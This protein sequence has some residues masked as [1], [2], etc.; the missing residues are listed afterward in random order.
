MKGKVG[1]S[2]LDA[3]WKD[4]W[5]IVVQVD[6]NPCEDSILASNA[7]EQITGRV[8]RFAKIGLKM[9]LRACQ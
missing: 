8:E 4:E 3:A 5:C 6:E 2:A 1:D 7:P 9:V